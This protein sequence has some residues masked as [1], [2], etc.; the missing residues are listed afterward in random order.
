[1]A[2]NG[3]YIYCPSPEQ[4]AVAAVLRNGYMTHKGTPEE[5]TLSIDLSSERVRYALSL[6]EG[7]QQGQSLNALLG[8]LFE[9]GLDDLN[10]EQYTQPF[11]DLFP[12]VGNKLTP[13]SAP[14][15][16]VAASNVVDGLAL[17][18]AWDDGKLAAGQNWGAGLPPP[19]PDQTAVIGL[20][21]NLDSYA[22]ALGDVSMAEAVFQIIRG[23]FGR[24]GTLMDAI[25][26]GDRPPNP[27]VA[28]LRDDIAAMAWAVENAL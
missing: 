17:R 9:A 25:S 11:R 26:K 14:T 23:N 4:A 6:L 3:G 7:V 1:L 8:Y 24:S 5:P 22:D 13:S 15:E 10:L 12:V 19:G 21:T 27:E 18:T 2:D 28:F 16:A 20:L